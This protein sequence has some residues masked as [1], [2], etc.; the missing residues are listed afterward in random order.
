MTQTGGSHGGTGNFLSLVDMLK[1]ADPKD[2]PAL[3]G[4]L[5]DI[6][7]EQQ[8][9]NQ[10]FEDIANRYELEQEKNKLLEEKNSSLE[11]AREADRR[12]AEAR[13][14]ELNKRVKGLEEILKEIAKKPGQKNPP[15]QPPAEPQKPI[16][17][18]PPQTPVQPQQPVIVN[19][20]KIVNYDCPAKEYLEGIVK[21]QKEI[22]EILKQRPVVPPVQ[23]PVQPPVYPPQPQQPNPPEGYKC[24]AVEMLPKIASDIEG[25]IEVI[26]DMDK[27]YDARLDKQDEDHAKILA[28]QDEIKQRLDD[29][30]KGL[31]GLAGQVKQ[32]NDNYAAIEKRMGA[33]EQAYAKNQS[34]LDDIL[35][36][37]VKI[38]KKLDKPVVPPVQPAPQQ[39]SPQPPQP[40]PVQ[41][42]PQ[43]VP[44]PVQPAQPPV[45]V[46]PWPMPYPMPGGAYPVPG[47]PP[48]PGGPT[49]PTNPNPP[50]QPKPEEPK[51]EVPK[52]DEPKPPY[53]P[54]NPK[55]TK[56]EEPK[57]VPP[58][59][60]PENPAPEDPKVPEEPNGPEYPVKPSPEVPEN[61]N[62][63]NPRGPKPEEPKP[64][65]HDALICMYEAARN[66][67]REAEYDK[68]MVY[69]NAIEQTGL[70]QRN[71]L[72]YLEMGLVKV[73]SGDTWDA[74]LD[75]EKAL[76][77]DGIKPDIENIVGANIGTLHRLAKDDASVP[78]FTNKP[79]DELDR[80]LV[81][82][83]P[84]N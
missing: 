77:A 63:E 39:P 33:L 60:V 58:P 2:L 19:P 7:Q 66:A 13:A 35:G 82:D 53:N 79:L 15:V 71:D 76:H 10:Q 80:I 1:N 43:P 22:L 21:A 25:L 9:A 31:A 55:P 4:M 69:L 81:Y 78:E 38:G 68:A 61:P 20:P 52:P 67:R 72:L 75:F 51:P 50:G 41:P 14:E 3:Q 46:V 84:V 42:V 47:W 17:V 34:T 57:P 73:G 6:Y 37:L 23:P 54:E 49:Y 29:Y 30:N 5:V 12:A 8:R 11:S 45:V 83:G 27:K 70:F 44:Y 59:N 26:F 62:P 36:E 74:A 16:I 24:P 64:Y 28:N 48:Q 32:N 40:V 18:N 65:D 56:P